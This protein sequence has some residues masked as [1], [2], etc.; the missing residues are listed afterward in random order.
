MKS[1]MER[2][3]GTNADLRTRSKDPGAKGRNSSSAITWHVPTSTPP[4]GE[5]PSL[6]PP[7]LLN[8]LA[9]TALL[10]PL[11]SACSDISHCVTCSTPPI[12]PFPPRPGL[13]R[14][15]FR[16][17]RTRQFNVRH[18]VAF[19]LLTQPGKPL[20]LRPIVT[21]QCTV[22][23]VRTKEGLIDVILCMKEGRK[24]KTN[25]FYFQNCVP[26]PVSCTIIK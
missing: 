13:T 8:S 19:I 22:S 15:K 24:E 9:S 10:T 11:N 12:P 2:M 5:R 26:V 1:V 18:F 16:S 3:P 6:S 23:R 14:E 17:V 21:L 7:F 25:R 20:R 4:A